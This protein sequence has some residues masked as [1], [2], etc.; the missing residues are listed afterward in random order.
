MRYSSLKISYGLF[1]G[2]DGKEDFEEIE[3]FKS[4]LSESYISLVKGIPQGR[5][6]GAYHFFIDWF[7]N[8]PLENY[9][10]IVVGYLG[11]KAID[12][13][14]DPYLDSLLFKPLKRAY[15][16]LK[17]KNQFLEVNTLC[18]E[19]SDSKIIIYSVN[20]VGILE[21]LDSILAEVSKR[22]KSFWLEDHF[23]EEIHIPAIKD[24]KKSI[25]F[26]RPPLGI[27]ESFTDL[28]QSSYQEFWG[29]K[30]LR[31]DL[32]CI[33]DLKR[34]TISQEVKFLDE[35]ELNFFNDSL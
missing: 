3:A 1:T 9:L 18:L 31:R 13:V 29:L 20:N 14:A 8:L 24:E 34:N 26:F 32:S 6:A 27:D 35:T 19:L 23:P 11:G 2:P 16:N 30:Y 28:S 12:K 7:I 15:E 21:T 33:Y 10:K 5:G 22:F 25:C 17:K 4:S